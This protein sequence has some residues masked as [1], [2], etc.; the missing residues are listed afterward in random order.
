MIPKTLDDYMIAVIKANPGETQRGW[1]LAA[2]REHE[3]D[4]GMRRAFFNYGVANFFKSHH[5]ATA[6]PSE[7]AVTKRIRHTTK[8]ARKRGER[9]LEQRTVIGLTLFKWTMQQTCGLLAKMGGAYAD[10]ARCGKPNQV[11]GNV[12]TNIQARNIFRRHGM[13][14]KVI[15]ADDA[16]KKAAA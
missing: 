7:I 14:V 16:T 10:L 8:R 6:S 13:D 15:V 4:R 1:E 9:N 12:I 11:L 3:K 2:W 5:V